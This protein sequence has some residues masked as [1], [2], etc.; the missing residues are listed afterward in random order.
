[1]LLAKSNGVTLVNHIVDV[2]SC[3]KAIRRKDKRDIPEDWWLALYYATVY[4]DL[5]KIDPEFQEILKK[6]WPPKSTFP[7]SLLSLL[8]FIP[9]EQIFPS[10]VMAAVAFHHWRDSFPNYLLGLGNQDM[11]MKAS[12]L[13][14][15]FNHGQIHWI[16]LKRN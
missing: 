3:I 15:R 2:L 8:F 5:G 13:S 12:L 11:Q 16:S 10:E 1:M 14:R 4:H 6:P 7:H 9:V